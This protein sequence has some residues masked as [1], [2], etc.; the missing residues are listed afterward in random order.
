MLQ[1]THELEL[2]P[3]NKIETHRLET[4]DF[5]LVL[6]SFRGLQRVQ[7]LLACCVADP[8]TSPKIP[9]WVR[10]VPDDID[11]PLEALRG[12]V[13]LLDDGL[14]TVL[15]SPNPHFPAALFVRKGFQ[16]RLPTEAVPK[17][18]PAIDAAFQ[19]AESFSQ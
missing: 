18:R 3:E 11:T 14:L 8:G 4:P 2:D 1:M 19:H 17:I 10:Y 5:R 6:T 9:R 12:D 13:E 15:C 16:V 7:F